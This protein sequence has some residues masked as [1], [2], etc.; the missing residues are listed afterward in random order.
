MSDYLYVLAIALLPLAGCLCGALIAEN[1]RLPRWTLGAALH[2]AAGIAIAVVSVDLV[3]RS[4]ERVP[5]WLLIV[6]FSVGAAFSTMVARGV[7]LLKRRMSG[8]GSH[9]AWMVYVAVATDLLSD[10][11]MIGAG[12][13]VSGSLGLLL[14][15]SQVVGNMPGGFAAISNFRDDHVSRSTRLMV[16]GSFA[17]PALGG[18]LGGYWLL[19]GSPSWVEGTALA[20]VVGLLLLATV[21]DL[22]PEAD[23]PEAARWISTA[24]FVAGFAFIV[25]LSSYIG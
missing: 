8:G 24:S 21:E 2:A 12:S 15:I 9:G 4:L 20:A 13:A 6:A 18:A 11:L 19:R 16:A 5:P 10:G 14:G 3:P 22:V 17:V 23:E 25:L 1:V 7:R